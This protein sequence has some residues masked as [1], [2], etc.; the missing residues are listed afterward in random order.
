MGGAVVKGAGLALDHLGVLRHVE[1]AKGG[2]LDKEGDAYKEWQQ[3]PPSL[4]V[5]RHNASSCRGSL[6]PAPARTSHQTRASGA[7][8]GAGLHGRSRVP[9]RSTR[10]EGAEDERQEVD[11]V[12]VAGRQ[13][14]LEMAGGASEETSAG[15]EE[16]RVRQ[17]WK[18]GRETRVGENESWE[19]TR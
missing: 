9:G 3:A 11:E 2:D 5:A 19:M 18:Q 13:I 10:R 8:H 16:Q 17:P 4:S 15:W 12:R 1:A 7:P 14:S 6:S